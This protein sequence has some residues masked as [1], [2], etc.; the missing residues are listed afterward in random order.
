MLAGTR[1]PAGEGS[2]GSVPHNTFTPLSIPRLR[3][4]RRITR[5]SGHP[6]PAVSLIS[7]ILNVG[8]RRLPVPIQDITLTLRDRHFSIIASLAVTLSTAS[9]TQHGE[10]ANISSTFSG[11]MR[12]L[13]ATQSHFWSIRCANSTAASHLLTPIVC[14]VA[15]SCLFKLL[16]SK[17]S[18]SHAVIWPTP[19]RTRAVNAAPPTPPNPTIATDDACSLLK[20]SFPIRDISRLKISFSVIINKPCAF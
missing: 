9:I 20:R 2:A 14:A 19:A 3:S 18:Q 10:W 15:N 5:A 6:H 7:T 1:E 4:S 16:D 17:Q 12:R 13:S 8:T 11:V